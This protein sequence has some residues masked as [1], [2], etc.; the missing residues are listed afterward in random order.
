FFFFAILAASFNW[1][2]S[3]GLR[4]AV[5]A[6]VL[7]AVVGYASSPQEPEFELNRFLLRAFALLVLGFLIAQWGGSEVTSKRRVGFLQNITS[8]SDSRFWI[9]RTMHLCLR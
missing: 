4:T 9:E 1:G 5:A 8:F 3:T 2:F 6:S 7:F